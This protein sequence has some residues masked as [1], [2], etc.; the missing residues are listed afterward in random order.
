MEQGRSGREVK[1]LQGPHMS[2][3]QRQHFSK[4][5][6]YW[7]TKIVQKWRS[8]QTA[9]EDWGKRWSD[10]SSSSTKWS[11]CS[12]KVLITKKRVELKPIPASVGVYDLS[13]HVNTWPPNSTPVLVVIWPI[14]FPSTSFRPGQR[15]SWTAI[16]SFRSKYIY[17]YIYTQSTG[18]NPVYLQ[19]PIYRAC[20][21]VKSHVHRNNSWP[22]LLVRALVQS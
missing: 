15:R 8:V 20:K 22:W 3:Q 7:C 10:K 14:L 21:P 6:P 12:S 19:N 9:C 18:G 16:F 2:H 1:S 17:L 5:K 4:Q 13:T 11:I